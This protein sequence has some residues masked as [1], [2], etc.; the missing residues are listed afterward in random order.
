MM[1]TQTIAAIHDFRPAHH[2]SHSWM[3]NFPTL[4]ALWKPLA[5]SF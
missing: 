1:P 2:W 5:V 3:H 4:S